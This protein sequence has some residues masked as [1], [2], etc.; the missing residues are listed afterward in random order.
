MC[1]RTSP[2]SSRCPPPL[3]G[4]ARK[5]SASNEKN[6]SCYRQGMAC[7]A[8]RRTGIWSLHPETLVSRAVALADFQETLCILEPRK[9]QASVREARS[10]H[11]GHAPSRALHA[12]CT[13][14]CAQSTIASGAGVGAISPQHGRS[15]PQSRTPCTKMMTTTPHSRA[16]WEPDWQTIKVLAKAASLGYL[17]G[18][19]TDQALSRCT[20]TEWLPD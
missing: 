4:E 10:Q 13:A 15:R 16:G 3:S 19:E 2:I 18:P 8:E 20:A 14:P 6:N 5:D 17:D 7:I 9:E 12:R 1:R 11:A